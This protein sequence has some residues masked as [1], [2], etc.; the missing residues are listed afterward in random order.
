MV[1]PYAP[2]HVLGAQ[3]FPSKKGSLEIDDMVLMAINRLRLLLHLHH[4]INVT[5]D[6]LFLT[7]IFL[8]KLERCC[9]ENHFLTK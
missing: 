6:I 1:E 4:S 5:A 7:I 2:F 9:I 3:R 8:I